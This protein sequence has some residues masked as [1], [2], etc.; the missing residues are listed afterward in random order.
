M[1]PIRLATARDKVEDGT[2]GHGSG[3]EEEDKLLG[4]G[5]E[6]NATAERRLKTAKKTINVTTAKGM[7][8]PLKAATIVTKSMARPKYD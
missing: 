1:T 3:A 4:P 8:V 2:L 7:L 5:H 6:K